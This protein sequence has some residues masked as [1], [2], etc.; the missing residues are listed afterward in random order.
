M[1]AAEWLASDEVTE[2]LARIK[3]EQEE[4]GFCDCCRECLEGQEAY[5]CYGQT[6]CEDCWEDAT[7]GKG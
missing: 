1:T 5:S 3:R 4:A 7:G 6:L 2:A